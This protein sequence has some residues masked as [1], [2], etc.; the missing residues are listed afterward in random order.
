VLDVAF[1]EDESRT[2]DLNAGANLALVRR[3][4][5]SLLKRVEAKGSIHTRRLMAAWDD[6]FLLKVLH[7]FPAESSA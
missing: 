1:R 4:A 6:T 2:H 7:G 3:V 5:V